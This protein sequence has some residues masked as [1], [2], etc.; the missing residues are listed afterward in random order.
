MIEITQESKAIQLFLIAQGLAHNTQNFYEKK[1]AGAGDIA[2]GAF[3]K[4]LRQEAQSAFGVDYSEKKACQG[5][6]Y[7]FDFYFP[8][9]ASAVEIALS[10]H[11]PTSEYEKDILKCLL[12]REDGLAVDSLLFVARP[13][14]FNRQGAPGPRRIA[15]FV[16]KKFALKVS[17]LELLPGLSAEGVIQAMKRV[18]DNRAK[19]QQR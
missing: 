5:V 8:D 19:L 10:L 2:S 7:A 4:M 18:D 1:G 12:A 3:M 16:L 15:D 13:G 17:V 9:E 11:N 14:A 6:G